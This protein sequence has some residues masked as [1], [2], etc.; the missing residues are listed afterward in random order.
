MGGGIAT[1]AWERFYEH[2][3]TKLLA[4]PLIKKRNQEL[5]DNLTAKRIWYISLAVLSILLSAVIALTGFWMV[6]LAAF[7][8]GMIFLSQY[9][10][11]N[12]HLHEVRLRSTRT[13]VPDFSV[14]HPKNS[15]T[16]TNAPKASP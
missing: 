9:F 10:D 2:D 14:L 8:L 6:A 4:F 15:E 3:G 16:K 1:E 12:G 5:K 11:A 7:V 13:L